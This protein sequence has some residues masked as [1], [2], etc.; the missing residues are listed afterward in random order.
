MQNLLVITGFIIWTTG[1]NT[2]TYLCGL[3]TIF[4]AT[5]VP[6]IAQQFSLD[7]SIIANWGQ[8]VMVAGYTFQ[9]AT[10][11]IGSGYSAVKTVG[12]DIATG[13]SKF[14]NMGK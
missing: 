12:K 5:L 11:L 14:K 9:T 13:I 4:S 3:G 1:T 6:K 10:K 2:V 8:G 7:T